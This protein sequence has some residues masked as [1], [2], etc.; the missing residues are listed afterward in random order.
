M[1][2]SRWTVFVGFVEH[3]LGKME[4]AWAFAGQSECP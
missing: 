2:T 4:G 3:E 1:G